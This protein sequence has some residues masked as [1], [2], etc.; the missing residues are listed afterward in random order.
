MRQLNNSS[1]RE[2]LPLYFEN[3]NLLE[4]LGF[5]QRYGSENLQERSE[6]RFGA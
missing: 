4:G 6:Q 1:C 3:F 2:E 5:A